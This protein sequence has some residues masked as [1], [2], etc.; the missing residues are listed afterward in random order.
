MMQSVIKIFKII[1]IVFAF[2]FVYVHFR[3]EVRD[4]RF[5]LAIDR[6]EQEQFKKGIYMSARGSVRDTV[7]KDIDSL[8]LEL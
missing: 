7:C 6:L 8:N 3:D 4:M 1:F 5:H 2:T